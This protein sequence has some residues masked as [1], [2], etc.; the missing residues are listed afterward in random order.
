MINNRWLKV[1][2]PLIINNRIFGMYL[3]RW[4][5]ALILIIKWCKPSPFNQL[6]PAI[7]NLAQRASSSA[8]LKETNSREITFVNRYFM[9]GQIGGVNF[10]IA[11]MAFGLK[12]R[13]HKV[14]I[15]CESPRPWSIRTSFHGV[16]IIG[17]RPRIMFF[18]KKSPPLYAGWS[19]AVLDFHK[20]QIDENKTKNTFATIAGLETLGTEM[21]PK[22]FNTICYLVTDHVI[23]KFGTETKENQTKRMTKFFESERYFLM[24]SKVTVIADSSAIV[25]DLSKVLELPDLLE[26][27]SILPI[28]WP[29]NTSVSPVELP[30]GRI[31][32]CIGSVSYRKGTRTLIDTWL[33]L[34]EDQNYSDCH[35]LICGPTSDDHET[36]SLIRLHALDSRIIRRTDMSEEE[37]N[38]ILENSDL[39]VIP[40]NYESF[41]I[42]A[43]EAM[44]KGCQII[45]SNVGGLTEVLGNVAVLFEAGNSVELG[46]KMKQSLNGDV[47]LSKSKILQRAEVFDFQNML[48]SLES[49]LH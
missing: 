36:E 16:E 30:P 17:V 5:S 28:G 15:L 37:K 47:R 13:G 38:Y 26:K 24:S 40:S 27:S 34:S 32:T 7:E 8:G 22:E 35:L 42:V 10:L 46:Q 39:V 11:L 18:D 49:E 2:G 14:Q 44:Q 4:L 31:I 48:R 23:H 1:I 33:E 41:G 6:S 45:A 43:V 9:Q 20:S 19:R 12:S 29:K 25:R 3:E 21:L